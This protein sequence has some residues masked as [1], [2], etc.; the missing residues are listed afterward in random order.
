MSGPKILHIASDEKFIDGALELFDAALPGGNALVVCLPAGRAVPKLV[1]RTEQV[2]FVHN[3]PEAAQ[4]VAG[5]LHGYDAVVIHGLDAFASALVAEAP[6]DTRFLWL[7][8]GYDIYNR[9]PLYSDTLH[10]PAT[11]RLLK[12]L[13]GTSRLED[14]RA[15]VRSL[16]FR[17][18]LPVLERWPEHLTSPA[19]PARF[20]LSGSV[21][22]GLRCI[23]RLCACGTVLPDEWPLVQRLGFRGEF[24]RFNYTWLE[25]LFP[26]GAE[27]A[28]GKNI[29]VG[30]SSSPACNHVDTFLELSRLDLRGRKV[31][32]PLGYGNDDY[33]QLVMRQGS[34]VLGSAFTPLENFMPMAEYNAVLESCGTVIMNHHRQ[35]A[36]GNIITSLHMGARVFL[37]ESNPCHAFF[38]RIGA[39]VF[40]LQRDLDALARDNDSLSDATVE[41]TRASLRA[42]YSK[43][44]S[45]ERTRA[46]VIGLLSPPG[47]EVSHVQ[48]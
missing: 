41:Q 42:E 17:A 2:S 20:L 18:S 12:E 5:S 31:V 16:L 9:F 29:L 10:Q 21:L 23:Q 26:S 43:A 3:E 15:S 37:N 8:W 1:K 28:S 13:K 38:S 4:R 46:I 35:Q 32:V 44:I 19:S 30:N 45:L 6:P 22:R 40:S 14:L 25:Q 24:F 7:A 34:D 39:R 11:Q 48:L 36:V 27:R 47:A 33:R